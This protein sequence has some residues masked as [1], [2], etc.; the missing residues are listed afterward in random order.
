MFDHFQTIEGPSEAVTKVQRSVFRALAFPLDGEDDFAPALERVEK[1]F[2]DATH[3]C[4]A[5][6]LV[7]RAG[8]T[9]V[10]SADA[11]EPAGTAGK[12]ILG[13]IESA[14]L[15]NVAVIVV[16]HYG[17]VKLGTG[18]LVRAYREAAASALAVANRGDRYIYERLNLTVPFDAMNAIYRMIAPPDIVLVE[19]QYGESTVFTIDVRKSQV[20]AIEAQLME[21]RIPVRREG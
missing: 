2:F 13:A 7:D 5:Y 4:W 6:R 14:S 18:G 17:G 20:G 11:G 8:E 12:P 15:F 16:R 19:Q 3:H 9:R 1:Q 21:R 10:R